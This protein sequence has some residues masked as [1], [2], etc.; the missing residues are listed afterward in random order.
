[1]IPYLINVPSQNLATVLWLPGIILLVG[2]ITQKKL[3]AHHFQWLMALG[4]MIVFGVT[5]FVFQEMYWA[6]AYH[7]MEI[8]GETGALLTQTLKDLNIMRTYKDEVKKG[9]QEIQT[10]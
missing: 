1:M 5:L 3:S 2:L 10:Q 9:L 8:A 6:G 7:E 4:A